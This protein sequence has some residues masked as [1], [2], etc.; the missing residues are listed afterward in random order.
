M[1]SSK[2]GTIRQVLAYAAWV[3][4]AGVLLMRST[5]NWRG[6]RAA[7]GTILG[8]GCAFL[9]YLVYLVRNVQG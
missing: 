2:L 1:S 6:R 7:W 4:F 9:V 3:L 8:F 5:G